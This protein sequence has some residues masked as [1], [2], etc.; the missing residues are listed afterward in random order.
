MIDFRGERSGRH[1]SPEILAGVFLYPSCN[2]LVMLRD[3][4]V[5][6]LRV[7][8]R[9]VTWTAIRRWAVHVSC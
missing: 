7:L 5:E 3:G 6:D 8:L 2:G 1:F 9:L 4:S